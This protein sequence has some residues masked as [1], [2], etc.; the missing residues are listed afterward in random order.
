MDFT[1]IP[2][3]LYRAKWREEFSR[4]NS[5]ARFIRA[6]AHTREQEIIA[7]DQLI[8]RL[9]LELAEAKGMRR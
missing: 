6:A 9:R 2:D 3:Y 4:A 7:S 8:E 5:L 1:P